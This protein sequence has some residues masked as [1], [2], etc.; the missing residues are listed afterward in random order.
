M[1]IPNNIALIDDYLGA[2]KALI[3]PGGDFGLDPGWYVEGERPAFPASP[4]LA[5]DVKVIKRAVE[6]EVPLL[7]ICAGMQIMAGAFGCKLTSKIQSYSKINLNHLNAKPAEGYAH[8]VIT[9][10]G[11]VFESIVGAKMQVNSRHMEGVVKLS[12]QIVL[13]GTSDDG[14]IEAIEV[15]GAKFALG[16]QWHPEYFREDS[17]FALFKSLVNQATK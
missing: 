17:N 11:T 10:K 9:E 1:A 3:V 5:F 14:I 12:D 15:K 8:A 4:R 6:K 7:G 13:S 16:V 2:V